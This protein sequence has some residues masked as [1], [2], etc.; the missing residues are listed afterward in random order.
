MVSAGADRALFDLGTAFTPATSFFDGRVQKRPDRML[1]DLLALGLAPPIPRLYDERA[2]GDS[3][4][5]APGAD[6]R[7]AVFVS[8]LHLDHASLLGYVAEDI[9][10]H[11]SDEGAALAAALEAAGLGSGLRRRVQPLPAG[12]HVRLG[13][14]RVTLLPVDHDVAGSAGFLIESESGTLVYTGD[15]RTHGYRARSTEDFVQAAAATRPRALIVETTRMGEE[16]PPTLTEEGV[17]DELVAAASQAPGL[18]VVV[19]YP[20]NVERVAR[21]P[22]VARRS[23][24]RLVVEAPIARLMRDRFPGEVAILGDGFEEWEGLP[25]DAIRSRPAA[26]LLQ[27]SYGQLAVLLDLRPPKGSIVLHAEGEP[28][29]PFDPAFANLQRWLEHLGIEH[30]V[31]RTSGHASPAEVVR[32][33]AAIGPE[34]VFPLHGFRP[35]LLLLPGVRQVLPVLGASYSLDGVAAQV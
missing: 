13:E 11:M 8:H 9:P 5:L 2:L 35:D 22:E 19:P 27:L 33:A 26:Y 17:V 20:R 29:G 25:A 23:G 14:L 4:G 16:V 6:G 18:A 31:I 21:L 15:F 28:I 12:G 30:R 7:T 34:V 3:T 10:I 1:P 32:I 24:R